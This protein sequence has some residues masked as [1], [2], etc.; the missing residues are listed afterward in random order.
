MAHVAAEGQV[1]LV[2]GAE[3]VD[4]G[5]RGVHGGHNHYHV[6]QHSLLVFHRDRALIQLA[7][8]RVRQ[9]PFVFRLQAVIL[10]VQ[11]R[12]DGPGLV[13]AP[14]QRDAVEGVGFP[15]AVEPGQVQQLQR[16]RGQHELPHEEHR[17]RSGNGKCPAGH[18]Y[19]WG[20]GFAGC[21]IFGSRQEHA[22][23]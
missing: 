3:G 9:Q 4:V 18:S 6:F 17:S 19:P 16:Q 7:G 23:L 5:S 8:V 2:P 21:K 22:P 11:R 15:G 10:R 14:G 1:H 12:E 20:C 13:G